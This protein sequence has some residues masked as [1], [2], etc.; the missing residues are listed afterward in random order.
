MFTAGKFQWIPFF[1][2]FLV[3]LFDRIS[4]LAHFFFFFFLLNTINKNTFSNGPSYVDDHTLENE[5]ILDSQICKTIYIKT[6]KNH[7][8]LVVAYV[9]IPKH[10]YLPFYYTNSLN[11]TAYEPNNLYCLS[12]MWSSST[13]F[14][15]RKLWFAIIKKCYILSNCILPT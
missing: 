10:L 9:Q 4:S 14:W 3:Y 1:H 2:G 5:N 8:C 11:W 13:F 6:I 7:N 15:Y 12:R